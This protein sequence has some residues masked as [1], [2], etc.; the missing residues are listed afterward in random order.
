MKKLKTKHR[1]GLD[2]TLI[3]GFGRKVRQ[4]KAFF[5]QGTIWK[6]VGRIL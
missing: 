3:K 1:I 2:A 5:L 6:K 4:L